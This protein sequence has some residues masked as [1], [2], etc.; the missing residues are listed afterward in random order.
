MKTS[1]TIDD[2]ERL[3][4]E[5]NNR[6]SEFDKH[7]AA[8]ETSEP[9]DLYDFFS[10][11]FRSELMP[12]LENLK[13]CIKSGI[14]LNSKQL[15]MLQYLDL[16]FSFSYSKTGESIPGL[17]RKKVFKS[18]YEL[19]EIRETINWSKVKKPGTSNYRKSYTAEEPRNTDLMVIQ[20]AEPVEEYE[21]VEIESVEPPV[22]KVHKTDFKEEPS[23]PDEKKEFEEN[24]DKHKIRIRTLRRISGGLFDK[25]F[26]YFADH[27]NGFSDRALKDVQTDGHVYI[28]ALTSPHQGIYFISSRAEA[29]EKALRM[30]SLLLDNACEYS[31]RNQQGTS[32]LTT[33]SGQIRKTNDTWHIERKARIAIV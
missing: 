25:K 26:A 17:R 4:R 3:I 1:F 2:V 10:R 7:P 18:F 21:I 9:V 11:K 12:E 29:Q 14:L 19:K 6:Q 24:T 5:L 27:N 22:K 32:I 20:R 15:E 28:L 8:D 13:H 31:L 23:E 16:Y 33:Q 30:P